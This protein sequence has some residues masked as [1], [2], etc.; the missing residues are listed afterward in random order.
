MEFIELADDLRIH[1]GQQEIFYGSTLTIHSNSVF[2]I[3]W[4]I[5]FGTFHICF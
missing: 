5:F 3:I 2:F 4:I 1:E